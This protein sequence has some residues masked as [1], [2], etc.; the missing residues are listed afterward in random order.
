[1]F[2]LNLSAAL[3]EF[4]SAYSSTENEAEGTLSQSNI[5]AALN[6]FHLH[7]RSS[8]VILAGFW[9]VV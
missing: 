4:F 3:R 2:S 6:W 8:V 7:G 1:M 9:E 5:L